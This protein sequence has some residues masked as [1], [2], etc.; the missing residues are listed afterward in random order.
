MHKPLLTFILLA[1]G[2]FSP[3]IGADEIKIFT[4]ENYFSSEVISQFEKESGHK[5][6]QIY[7]DDE[8][9]RDSV[10]HSGKAAIYDLFILDGLTLSEFAKEGILRKVDENTIAKNAHHF[11]DEA[12][13]VCGQYGIPYAHGTIGIGYRSSVVSVKFN[14]WMD[15]FNYAKQVPGKLVLPDEDVDTLAIALMAL[16]YHP[17]TTKKPELQEA[18]QLLDSVL[19]NLLAFRN[20]EGY[21]LEKKQKSEMDVAVF[22][23]GEK[24]VISNATGQADWE[25][26]I[27]DEGTLVWYECLSSH[28]KKPMSKATQEFLA[29]ISRPDI[30]AKNAQDIWFATTNKDALKLADDEYLKGVDLL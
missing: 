3:L 11:S 29:Y 16:G 20:S 13:Q 2:L 12:N 1:L 28:S 17:L 22:Y 7:F 26:V 24:E 15:V 8:M 18:Y 6:S 30:A 19:D 23:S 10:V 27:P 9:L 25:Y 4:W 5:V 14:S 21:A